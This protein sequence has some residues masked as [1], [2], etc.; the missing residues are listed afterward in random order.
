MTGPPTVVDVDTSVVDVAKLMEA[1]ELGAVVVCDDQDR[2]QGMVTDRDL[3]VEVIAAGRDPAHTSAGELLL[4]T[5]VATVDESDSL[6]E[7]VKTMKERAVRRLPVMSGDRVV[8]LISQADVARVDD[9][10]AGEL[11][12][13]LSSAR[14]NTARG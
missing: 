5:S 12:E 7:A 8:G 11:I 9:R 14:D 10:L 2:P 4:G 13:V 1:R 6:E 3:A